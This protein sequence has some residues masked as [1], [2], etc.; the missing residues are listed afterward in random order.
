MEQRSEQSTQPRSGRPLWQVDE[1]VTTLSDLAMSV[2][3][4]VLAVRLFGVG[5][6]PAATLL[7]AG[8]ASV[9]LSALLGA[10]FHGY[11]RRWRPTV[12]DRVW[13]A[14]LAATGVTNLLLLL[15]I[16]TA[17]FRGVAALLV[18][19]V[20]CAKSARYL[21]SIRGDD[22]FGPAIVDSGITIVA[23][24][25]IALWS[26]AFDGTGEWPPWVLAACAAT[27]VGGWIQY[28]GKGLHEHLNHNDIF[29]LLQIVA[30]FLFY[31]G[32]LLF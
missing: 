22:D 3:G 7:S 29:H 6:E 18:V 14:V 23:V 20:A 15:A 16:A 2:I 11:M 24:T 17:A 25:L 28:H 27:V 1:P 4:S 19:V 26:F 5:E 13:V 30:C 21:L 10:V 12:Q 31:R 9:A 8:L 32:G